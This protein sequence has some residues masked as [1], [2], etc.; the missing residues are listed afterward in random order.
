MALQHRTMVNH[1]M[2][3]MIYLNKKAVIMIFHSVV[4]EVTVVVVDVAEVAVH[5]EDEEQRV[6]S[7]FKKKQKKIK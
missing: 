6:K 4:I 1:I 7:L 3:V 5:G 2:V